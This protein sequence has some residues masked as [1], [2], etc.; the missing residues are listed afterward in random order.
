MPSTTRSPA[1]NGNRPGPGPAHRPTPSAAGA[2]SPLATARF[3]RRRRSRAAAGVLLIVGFAFAGVVVYGGAGDRQSVLAA[4]RTVRAGSTLT[5]NDVT[6]VL[7]DIETGVGVVPAGERDRLIGKVAAVD[8]VPGA[9]LAPGQVAERSK[10]PSGRAIVGAT[11][12]EG[13]FP[14]GLRAGDKVVMFMVPPDNSGPTEAAAAA[15]AVD[16]TVVEV[17]P[18]VQ[19]GAVTLALELDPG[20]ASPVA[21]AAFRGRLVVV[22]G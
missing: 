19:E 18:S 5:A 2:T 17:G 1:T 14:L 21:V 8:L 20:A 4:V 13:L 12:K 6:P 3:A 11:L 10:A 7:A 22:A 9:L 15:P 16:A